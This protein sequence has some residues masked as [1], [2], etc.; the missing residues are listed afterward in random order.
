MYICP[1]HRRLTQ[2]EERGPANPFSIPVCPICENEENHPKLKSRRISRLQW[3]VNDREEEAT[4]KYGGKFVN[5]GEWI[6]FYRD[7]ILMKRFNKR[8]IASI[9]WEDE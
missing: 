7:G 1:L 2:K 8:F 4:L 5:N 6:D 9:E 3:W